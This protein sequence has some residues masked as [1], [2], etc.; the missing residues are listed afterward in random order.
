MTEQMQTFI[1]LPLLIDRL[2]HFISIWMIAVSD[3]PI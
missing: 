1:A 2:N 3:Y